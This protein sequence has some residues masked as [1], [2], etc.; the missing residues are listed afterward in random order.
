MILFSNIITYFLGGQGS[1][2]SL[3]RQCFFCEVMVQEEVFLGR[4][5]HR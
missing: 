4:Q 1:G 2:K 3:D 5:R